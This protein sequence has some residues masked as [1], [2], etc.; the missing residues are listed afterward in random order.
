MTLGHKQI[1]E[2]MNASKDSPGSFDFARAARCAQD[3][4]AVHCSQDDAAV[5]PACIAPRRVLR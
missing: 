4:T 3:D 5:L 2:K 1:P